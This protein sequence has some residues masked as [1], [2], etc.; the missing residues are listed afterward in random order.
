LVGGDAGRVGSG[1]LGRRPDDRLR[2]R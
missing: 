2:Q 1:L